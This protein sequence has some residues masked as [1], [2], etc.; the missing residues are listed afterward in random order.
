MDRPGAAQEEQSRIAPD[1]QISDYQ[2][3]RYSN[4]VGHGV[5]L[6]PFR[7]NGLKFSS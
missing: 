4:D 5:G 7:G 1:L 6:I 3:E 2:A